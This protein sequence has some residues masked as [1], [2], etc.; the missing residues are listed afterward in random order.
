MSKTPPTASPS[1]PN[2]P[3]TPPPHASA[4][5]NSPSAPRPSLTPTTPPAH[6]A[7]PAARPSASS[8]HPTP[9][10]SS[11]AKKAPSPSPPSPAFSPLPSSSP[12]H[13]H[14]RHTITML[15][16]VNQGCVISTEA[17]AVSLR[18]REICCSSAPPIHSVGRH[19]SSPI[20]K[21][22]QNYTAN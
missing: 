1:S 12:T 20:S 11:P 10:S 15:L 7:E 8:A 3:P 9:P 16:S 17:A 21:S 4:S 5:P 18:S 6:P 14:V 13:N 2:R 19:P 22:N